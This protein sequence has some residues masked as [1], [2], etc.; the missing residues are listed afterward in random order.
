MTDPRTADRLAIGEVLARYVWALSDKDWNAFRACFTA[1]AHVDYTTAGGIAGSAAEAATWLEQ[2]LSLFDVTVSQSSNVVIDFI[3][4][5][6][7]DVRSLYKMTMR[8][9]GDTPTYMEA[10][11]CYRDK[12]VRAGSGWLLSDRFEQLLYL[13]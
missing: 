13:R 4:N 9:P 8:I 5:D 2:T 12:A 1:D 6:R 7:A 3:G 10:C 11:G